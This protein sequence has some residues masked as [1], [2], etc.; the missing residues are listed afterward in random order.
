[1]RYVSCTLVHATLLHSAFLGKQPDPEDHFTVFPA[2]GKE[3]GCSQW[4]K[5]ETGAK[6]YFDEARTDCAECEP[7][8]CQCW[9]GFHTRC[10]KC[11]V[12]TACQAEQE[13]RVCEHDAFCHKNGELLWWFESGDGGRHPRGVRCDPDEDFQCH[14]LTSVAEEFCKKGSV[15]EDVTC[16]RKGPYIPKRPA[17]LSDAGGASS[18]IIDQKILSPPH[19]PYF[20]FEKHQLLC[21]TFTYEDEPNFEIFNG[22]ETPGEKTPSPTP[23]PEIYCAAM[24]DIVVVI[25]SSGSLTADGFENAVT[26]VEKMILHSKVGE[27]EVRYGVVQYSEPGKYPQANAA[28]VVVK[29]LS[30]DPDALREAV[31]GMKFVGGSTYT[32]EAMELALDM[33]QTNKRADAA[34]AVLLVTDGQATDWHKL[35]G[36]AKKVKEDGS[37]LMVAV[38]TPPG[39]NIFT[40]EATAYSFGDIV[41]KPVDDNLHVEMSYET[42]VSK[43]QDYAT[44]LCN[45]AT[46]KE[47][48]DVDDWGW[49]PAVQPANVQPTVWIG[50]R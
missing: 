36:A 28:A 41:S 13:L 5:A 7:G 10:V 24:V 48:D 19:E 21:S 49:W 32:G 4:T 33:L 11:G 38:V 17:R 1:M 46:K 25:D 42:L 45:S 37:H 47:E 44:R 12:G 3:A 22:G 9:D 2:N 18:Y 23:A 39:S 20:E 14:A 29:P 27:Q 40:T 35:K 43:V 26:F 15:V 8:G 6:C 50:C 30:S 16:E 31:R 34:T